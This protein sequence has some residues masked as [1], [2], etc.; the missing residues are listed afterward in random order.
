MKI[1]SLSKLKKAWF[2]KNKCKHEK[3]EWKS[4]SDGVTFY[5]SN[6][7]YDDW[8]CLICQDC[9]KTLQESI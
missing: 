2:L 3:K 4:T 1:F 7:Y 9:G 8:D 6:R 5:H